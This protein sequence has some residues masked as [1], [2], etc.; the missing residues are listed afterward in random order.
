MKK[1]ILQISLFSLLIFILSGCD[2]EN[3]IGKDTIKTETAADYIWDDSNVKTITFN[4]NSITTSSTDVKISGTTATINAGGYYVLNGNLNDGQ[5]VVNAPKSKLKIM[6]N[7][8]TMSNST[9]SPFYILA[10][11]KVIIF[12]KSGTTSTIT[13][14]A[15]YTNIGEPQATIF[16]NAYLAFTG[17]GTLNVNA[18]HNDAISSDDE[19]IIN[20]GNININ[21]VDDGIRGK[22]YM[23]IHDGNIKA[24]VN[25]GHAL[26]VDSTGIVGNGYL[27][28]DGGNL[29]LN[30]ALGDGMNVHKRI[31]IE[32]GQFNITAA[33]SQAFRS[34][35]LV[36]ISGGTI[37]VASSKQGIKS[38]Y[39]NISGGTSSFTTF[40]I[41]INATYETATTQPDDSQLNISGGNV[42]IN[43]LS[44]G[45]A[46]DGNI[47]IS[48]GTSIIQGPFDNT[49]LMANCLGDFIISGG[50][51]A[52]SGP[53]A[54]A[55]IKNPSNLSSQ[56][57]IKLT[58]LTLGSQ[59][60]N[61]QDANSK[62]IVTFKPM[63]YAY[64]FIFS[65]P[66]LTTGSSYSVYTGGTYT[67]GTNTNGYFTGG[68]YNPGL[69]RTTFTISEKVTT[70]NF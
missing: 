26:K 20:N 9:T 67:G 7:G 18:N 39:V 13:D 48:G 65:A 52:G 17:D 2:P 32:N 44:H 43:T 62:S 16:S 58:S 56:N 60:I 6:L 12:L 64:Y 11:S 45:L 3:V 49:R 28:I 68:S 66:E 4:D 42:Y 23:V 54:G 25:T 47:N 63:K 37:T 46:S 70:V 30:S 35:S 51:L 38:P 69:K 27:K 5:L 21:A 8:V 10:A 14:P 55:L 24:T 53:N 19:V 34:D 31:L 22:D 36:S 40:K 15:N 41:A 33:E 1:L 61:I 50:I 29:T 59:M 57:S